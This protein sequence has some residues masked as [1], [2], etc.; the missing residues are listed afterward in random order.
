MF[1]WRAAP[2][3]RPKRSSFVAS[4][5]VDLL[6]HRAFLRTMP[7]AIQRPRIAVRARHSVVGRVVGRVLVAGGKADRRGLYRP[8]DAGKLPHTSA[9]CRPIESSGNAQARTLPCVLVCSAASALLVPSDHRLP[10]C[11]SSCKEVLIQMKC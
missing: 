4:L 2:A 10:R 6:I 11:F 8:T 1:A 9:L 5:D 3:E 7:H